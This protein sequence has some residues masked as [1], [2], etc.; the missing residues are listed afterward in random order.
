[1]KRN[2]MTCSAVADLLE[3][4]FEQV[5]PEG[6]AALVAAHLRQCRACSGKLAQIEKITA[7]LAAVPSSEPSADLA[8]LISARVA[9]LPPAA[10]RRWLVVGWRRLEVL[11]AAFMVFLAAWRYALPLLL[12][13]EAGRLRI[14]IWAKHATAQLA[15]WAT[16]LAEPCH[17]L[18]LA[19]RGTPEALRPVVTA[20][21]PTVALYTAA[22]VV[23]IAAVI[24]IAHRTHRAR[25]ASATI[26]L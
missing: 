18:W 3:A 2:V 20:V 19:L 17:R 7:A 10:R 1:M 11:A 13:E 4:Y 12:S 14:I 16:A 26:L 6:K 15:I 23:I 21:A 22:K 24:V 25:F 8:R 5:L 9:A